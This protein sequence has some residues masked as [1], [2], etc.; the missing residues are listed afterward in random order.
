MVGGSDHEDAVVGFEA[1]DFVEKVGAHVVGDEGVEVFKDEVAGGE[2][3]GFLED[4]REGVFRA[5]VLRLSVTLRANGS[6]NKTHRNQTP[7]IQARHAILPIQ[8][9]LHHGLD[10]DRL[11]VPRRA[12]INDSPLPWH[13][14][15]FVRVLALKEIQVIL[16]KGLLHVS[17]QND[18]LPARSLDTLPQ[19]PTL[20]PPSVII[21][22]NLIQQR[23]GPFPGGQQQGLGEVRRRSQDVVVLQVRV[24][25][26]TVAPVDDVQDEFLGL[27]FE[28][29]LGKND[30][31]DQKAG[32]VVDASG[33]RDVGC[34]GQAGGVFVGGG[35]EV[36]GERGD[37]GVAGGSKAE[38]VDRVD[39][40]DG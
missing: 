20:L 6:G 40:C 31:F 39:G 16:D 7:H 29:V 19:F 36:F 11:P 13:L 38:K 18:I 25:R 12:P 32:R 34:C 23:V 17:I 5:G 8:Q 28:E 2:L 22:P 3:A 37:G 4:L 1:V 33:G 24:G 30:V 26:C 14:Q 27:P 35:T 10:T 21:Y 9:R 15:L